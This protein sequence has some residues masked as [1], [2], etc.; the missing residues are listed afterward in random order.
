[1]NRSTEHD[2]SFLPMGRIVA[3]A[4]VAFVLFTSSA[5]AAGH[6]NTPGILPPNSTP[7]GATYGEWSAAWWQWAYSMPT[8]ENPL[9]D[10]A[11]CSAGQSDHVW[12]LGG[13][14][15]RSGLGVERTCTIPP[16]TA[17]FFPVVNIAVDNTGCADSL[18]PPTVFTVDE[19]RAIAKSSMDG[20]S[21]LSC[22]IDGVPVRG[23]SVPSPYRVQSPVFSYTLPA[24]P[25]NLINWLLN[26]L[27]CYP[28]PPPSGGCFAD[29]G[30]VTP[31][32]ADGFYLMVA[33]LSAGEHTIHFAGSLSGSPFEDITYHIT[34]ARH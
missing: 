10:T 3:V 28:T 13:V 12:F 30:T 2:H 9:F 23:L 34:V 31:V 20:A 8:T 16:G 29:G 15:G 33:P 5:V 11:D 21:D 19:L 26:F 27:G 6:V 14:F 25:D 4:A 18:C 22:T 17:L 1:M 7:H 24:D 32:V